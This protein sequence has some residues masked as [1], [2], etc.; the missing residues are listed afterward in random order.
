MRVDFTKMHGLGNDFI[1]MNLP[2]DAALPSAE[3][4]RAL[5]D[6]HGGIGFDQALVLLPP[7]RSDTDVFYRVF[8]ADGAE[9]E[10]CG[11]G[12][13][14][15]AALLHRRGR[16]HAG[17]LTMDSVGGVLHAHVLADGRVAVDMG[18][19]NFDPASLPFDAGA[20]SATYTL[21]VAGERIEFG[22]LSLGNPHAVLRVEAVES[23]PVERIGRALQSSPHFPRQVNV[24]FMQIIDAGQIRLRVYERGVGETLAC[25]TG[26]CAAVAV[27][28]NLGLLGAEVEVRVPGGTLS[29]HWDG[30]GQS[31]LA[32]RPGTTGLRRT[33]RTSELLAASNGEHTDDAAIRLRGIAA[34]AIEE[35]AVVHYLHHN[36]DFFERHPQLLARLRLQHPRNGSTVSLIERQVEVL[37]EKIQAQEQKLAEFVRVARANNLLAE[38]IHRF[39]RRLLRTSGAGPAIAEIEASL[40]EDFDT[41]HTVL[42]LA[43]A[44]AA[45]D[46]QG[47]PQRFLRRVLAD[48]PAL[49]SFDSLFAAGKPRCGQIRDTQREFLFGVRSAEHRLGGADPAR[50]PDAG[51]P[52]GARQRRSRPLPSRHEHRVPVAHGRADHRRARARLSRQRSAPPAPGQGPMTPQ[53]S[54]WLARFERYL[55]TERRLSVHTALGLPARSR[56]AARLVRSHRPQRLAAARPSAHPQPLPRAAMRVACRAAAS[57]AGSRRVRTLLQ[58]PAA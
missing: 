30:A 49:R 24:G 45:D 51:G 40:R 25:G 22:A 33:R 44:S 27:G 38:K 28:R 7:R 34:E 53:A 48:D 46:E 4:W 37:R 15:V 13:R 35:Q 47:A 58:L 21:A 2:A 32:D 20:P 14:C 16:G 57:S 39:T 23:A 9:V 5:A 55:G 42:V 11:N 8:N 26:A 43:A 31:H 56:G 18:V 10:Q 19:P 41:F 50:R 29:V 3:Q 54:Q 52:A 12:A 1:V 6:R 17:R 36:A